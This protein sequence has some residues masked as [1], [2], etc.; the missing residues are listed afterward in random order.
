MNWILRMLRR[1]PPAFSTTELRMRLEIATKDRKYQPR[2]GLTFC[3]YF[4]EAAAEWFGY[5]GFGGLMANGIV[6]KMRNTPNTF[7]LV[8]YKEAA[9]H[10]N[11]GR[12]V[13]A[14]QQA[15][16][17]GHVCI[18]YPGNMGWSGSWNCEVPLAANVGKNCWVGLPLS[19][20]FKA[21][22]ELFLYRG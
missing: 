19:R 20:A 6:E 2:D 17:H 15:E 8:G 11:T 10:A 22:P 14:G 12:L 9:E 18:V 4:V 16:P 5:R 13:I 21:Q 3:N 1:P 7:S